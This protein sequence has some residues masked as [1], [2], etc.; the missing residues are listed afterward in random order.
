MI[1]WGGLKDLLGLGSL[2]GL[3]GLVGRVGI[4]GLV[5]HVRLIGWVGLEGPVGLVSFLGLAGLVGGNKTNR[6][7]D[8]AKDQEKTGNT[9][10]VIELTGLLPFL[11]SSTTSWPPSTGLTLTT[12][13]FSSKKA[14]DKKEGGRDEDCQEVVHDRSAHGHLCNNRL[15]FKKS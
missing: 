6:P 3:I 4:E 9:R 11:T 7:E 1:G 12:L 8:K 10:E 5:C 15:F 14:D 2:V 13:M